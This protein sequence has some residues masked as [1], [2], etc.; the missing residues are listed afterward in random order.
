MFQ[1]SERVQQAVRNRALS[2]GAI[3]GAENPADIGTKTVGWIPGFESC[4]AR[5]GAWRATAP[6]MAKRTLSLGS[7]SEEMAKALKQ[8]RSSSTGSVEQVRLLMPLILMLTQL[9]RTQGL[10][11]GAPILTFGSEDGFASMAAMVGLGSSV[12]WWFMVFLLGLLKLLKW[13]FSLFLAQ[14][15]TGR[16]ARRP[17]SSSSSTR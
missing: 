5:W 1:E 2:I 17:R 16:R 11:L 15:E 6:L 14:G 4:C 9:G 12:W 3:S 13:G 7:K 10:S 8:M